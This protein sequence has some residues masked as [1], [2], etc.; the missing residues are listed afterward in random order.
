MPVS[1]LLFALFFFGSHQ[2]TRVALWVL[3]DRPRPPVSVR[4]SALSD[5]G[6]L[7]VTDGRRV[8]VLRSHAVSWK[9]V[10]TRSPG[11]DPA[12]GGGDGI[13]GL[14]FCGSLLA[15]A[16][17]AGV[18]VF[19]RS[20]MVRHSGLEA[21]GLDGLAGEG[22]R[23]VVWA[24]PRFWESWDCGRHWSAARFVRGGKIVVVAVLGAATVV[25]TSRRARVFF[26]SGRPGY[27]LSLGHIRAA[28]L[29]AR[30]RAVRLALLAHGTVHLF[31]F[32]SGRH[33]AR[34]VVGGQGIL[35]DRQGGFW[36][37][38]ESLIRI[39][40][41]GR[42]VRREFG[43]WGRAQP[44]AS[45]F[46]VVALSPGGLYVLR[47]ISVSH[48]PLRQAPSCPVRRVRSSGYPVRRAFAAGMAP[49]LLVS[50]RWAHSIGPYVKGPVWTVFLQAR[51]GWKADLAMEVDRA[52][53]AWIGLAARQRSVA[54]VRRARCDRW[55]ALMVHAEVSKPEIFLSLRLG[56]EAARALLDAPDETDGL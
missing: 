18:R 43:L 55:R 32:S 40:W 36:V 26:R 47:D 6:D 5:R 19:S 7:A 24:G 28:A 17:R 52:R 21:M 12:R 13:T 37:W 31:D 34:L 30:G 51:W 9:P 2:T 41:N 39:Q 3:D 53:T 16:G 22:R 46:G 49:T 8:Y 11:E 56:L 10:E 14:R 33:L 27:S 42:A 48:V 29:S 20:G 45:R 44:A 50:G 38:G 35:S 4:R 1:P 15:V 25:V 54:L 23:L